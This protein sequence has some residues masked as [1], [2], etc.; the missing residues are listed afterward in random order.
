LIANRGIGMV[1]RASLV[2]AG[3][4]L[5]VGCQSKLNVE[6]SVQ[7]EIGQLRTI[8]VDAPKYEQTVAVTVTADTPVDLYVFL[9]KNQ[10]AAEQDIAF[11]KKSDLILA[12][13]DKVQ[14][15]TVEAKVPAKEAAI[16]MIRSG[17]KAG[18]ATL[19]IVGK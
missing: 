15:D 1:P 17:G 2:V 14:N 12:G 13:K 7:F 19:K 8:E 6:R 9:R 11:G 5:L 10:E 16:V 4:S 18:T 3:V